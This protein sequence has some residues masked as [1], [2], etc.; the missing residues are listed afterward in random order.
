MT[1]SIQIKDP[2]TRK[3]LADLKRKL[4]LADDAIIALAITKLWLAD[5][6]DTRA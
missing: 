5:G 3:Q 1:Q 4:K 6:K 2:V